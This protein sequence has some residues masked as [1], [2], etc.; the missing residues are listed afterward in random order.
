MGVVHC[1]GQDIDGDE[2]L[3]RADVAMYKVR[4]TGRARWVAYDGELD[5]ALSTT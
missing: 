3:R 5:D 4:Q 2:L 1:I